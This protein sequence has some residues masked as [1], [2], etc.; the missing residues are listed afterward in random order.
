MHQSIEIRVKNRYFTID[1][2]KNQLPKTM[3]NL[4]KLA[5]LTFILIGFFKS[6]SNAGYYTPGTGVHWNFDDLVTN[7]GGVVTFGSG[8]YTVNDTIRLR[9]NDTLYIS[10]DII[11][12]FALNKSLYSSGIFLV[13]PPTGTLFTA[14]DTTNKWSGIKIDSNNT[15]VIRKLTM[16]YSV[17]L[18]INDCSILVD[19]CIFRNNGLVASTLTNAVIAPTRTGS[20]IQNCQFLNN[21][22]ACIQSGFN[23]NNPMRIL[24]NYFY[25]NDLLQVNTPA[26]NMSCTSLVDT[27]FIRN[28]QILHSSTNSGGI[29][30]FNSAASIVVITGNKII[31]N[32]YGINVQ[33]GNTINCYIGYNQIDS[34]NIQGSSSLGGSGIAFSGGTASSQ[35]NTRVT[36]NIIRWNLWGITIQ[37]RAK[38]NIGNVVN[39]D[40]SD[41]GK[42]YFV[43]NTNGTTPYIDLYNN[44]VD[45]IYAQGN[46]F[47]TNNLDSVAAKIFDFS[48]SPTLGPV[49]YTPIGV[50]ALGAPVNYGSNGRTG[51]SLY[52]FAN[53]LPGSSPSQPSFSWRDTTGSTSLIY[54]HTLST[55]VSAGTI[56]DGRFDLTGLLGGSVVRSFG[57][58]YSNLY[59]GTNGIV[60][61][62]AFDPTVYIAPPASGLPQSL[63]NSVF[64]LW[65]NLDFLNPLSP[66]FN[67]LSYKITTNEVIITYENAFLSGG[68][69][70]DYVSF[71]VILQKV[72]PASQNSNILFQ[73]DYANA[74]SNFITRYNN[75]TLPAHLVGLEGTFNGG[76]YAE[77]RYSNGTTVVAPGPLFGSPLAVSFGPNNTLLPVE[78]ASF[79]SSVSNNNVELNW[80]T[81]S[82]QNNSGFAVERK[83]SINSTWNNIGFIAG[84]G[85]STTERSYS[86][87]DN[88]IATGRY[89]YRLKQTDFNG[90]FKYYELGNEVIVGIPA[91]FSLAQNY[92]N[93]F[94]PVTNINFELPVDSKVSIKIFDISGR[95]VSSLINEARPAGY[96]SVS[97]NAS[98]LSSGVYFYKLSAEGSGQKFEVTK[99]MMLIK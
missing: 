5:L 39:A 77:Y 48:D 17:A 11:V 29:S 58:D 13:N 10:T 75:N 92:P 12:K 42:N 3:K 35:Q 72:A 90:N 65:M 15:S 91:K 98:S 78:L 25:G 66:G 9:K 82:E 32:R 86:F 33:G 2:F 40:T 46:F 69:I 76:D 67:R 37:N 8:F 18:R 54:G 97:F 45:S 70:G 93:P 47:A 96:Y 31:S 24:N 7:S 23:I 74:G 53:S 38:P 1:Q 59:V 50:N 68:T 99:K 49:Y 81:I 56:D 79:T 57:T 94:N 26:I 61:F 41:D 60:S 30:I 73:Y 62:N 71:Q 64:P 83:N 28:N 20:T 63:A 89:S 4:F 44:T 52:Y 55:P 19:S 6:D 85:N 84:A 21:Y 80:R 43:N 14:L 22:R 34:N 27:L 16:E 51:N 36:G 95:E 88:S 87:H